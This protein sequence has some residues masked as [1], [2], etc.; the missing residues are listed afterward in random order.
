MKPEAVA[1]KTQSRRFPARAAKGVVSA[2]GGVMP[3]TSAA[4]SATGKSTPRQMT[5]HFSGCVTTRRNHSGGAESRRAVEGCSETPEKTEGCAGYRPEIG[6]ARIALPRKG[7]EIAGTTRSHHVPDEDRFAGSVEDIRSSARPAVN[8]S[9]NTRV[10]PCASKAS[11][12]A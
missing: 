7:I 3:P 10:A 4:V 2:T 12:V 9:D 5:A 11:L 1:D 8:L 6:T